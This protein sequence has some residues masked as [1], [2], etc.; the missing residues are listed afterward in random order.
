MTSP[1]YWNPYSNGAEEVKQMPGE[2]SV[3]KRN[4][5]G[6]I[7][8]TDVIAIV[9]GSSPIDPND[10]EDGWQAKVISR[11][12][13]EH[14]NTTNINEGVPFNTK[15]PG[16]GQ[17]LWS[18]ATLQNTLVAGAAATT[19]IGGAVVILYGPAL[20]K[21]FGSQTAENADF[22]IKETDA[23]PSIVGETVMS[24]SQEKWQDKA[25]KFTTDNAHYILGIGL[26]AAGSFAL[27]A[28]ASQEIEEE[29][30]SRWQERLINEVVKK[31][32]PGEESGRIPER[33]EDDPV[34]S[35][36]TCPITLA[37]IRHPYKSTE[38]R[39]THIFEQFA[40]KDWCLK[41]IAR[42]EDPS[43][44]LCSRALDLTKMEIVKPLSDTI[45]LRLLL[46]ESQ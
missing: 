32:K 1:V 2:T 5:Y 7:P 3:R 27:Y 45:E 43:C 34:L 26:I 22:K 8:R 38:A 19:V 4:I 41:Q 12:A 21:K 14:F 15:A 11:L 33:F 29:S 39:C 30:F 37:P 31:P 9:K 13:A 35:A 25:V 28:R 17:W 46:L 10:S 20:L 16:W 44:P 36:N 18:K 24:V 6:P 42:A 40:I 23:G